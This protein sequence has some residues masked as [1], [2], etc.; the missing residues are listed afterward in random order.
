MTSVKK[1]LYIKNIAELVKLSGFPPLEHPV[2]AIIRI[3]E[4]RGLPPSFF[5]PV[6]FN[7]YTAG[8]KNNLS[9]TVR[10]GR[11]TYDFSKGVLGFTAPNQ[12]LEISPDMGSSVTGW[13]LFFQKEF[14]KDHPLQ[15][16]IDQYG[17][18]DYQVNEALHLSAKEEK[19]IEG[20]FECISAEYHDNIDRF[21]RE[22]I[23]SYLELLLNYSNRFY[24]RQ[25]ITRNQVNKEL[26]TRFETEL[27][28]YFKNEDYHNHGLPT[29]SYFAEALNVSPNY[30]SDYL[31]ANS[32]KNTQEHIHLALIDKAKTLLL[33]SGHSVSEV[34]YE[35]GF[36]YPQYFSRLFKQKTGISPREFRVSQN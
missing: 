12:V 18:F 28:N 30:L 10:Y 15:K 25:F 19:I 34:A 29:V 27:R 6:V 24:S 4:L 22:V 23:L 3:E 8:L 20:I 31:R 14:I 35:L 17:F 33:S 36:A 2:F 5:A 16:S 26:L 11:T 32:A 7:F 9:N 1:P 21:S 13:M